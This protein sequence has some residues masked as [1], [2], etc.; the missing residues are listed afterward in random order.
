MDGKGNREKEK[1]RLKNCLNGASCS[2]AVDYGGRGKARKLKQEGSLG[3]YPVRNSRGLL[4][5]YI[6]G[7]TRTRE[8]FDSSPKCLIYTAGVYLSVQIDMLILW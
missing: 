3:V 8:H 2:G 4:V 1:Q 7:D 6:T 5:D